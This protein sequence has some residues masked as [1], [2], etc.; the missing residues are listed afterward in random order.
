[1][2]TKRDLINNLLLAVKIGI[3]SS[4]AIYI[5]ELL[6]LEY[7]ASAGTIALLTLMTSKWETVRLSLFR[8]ITFE[9]SVLFSA[10]LF[11]RI[12]SLWISY[13]I[14]VFLIVTVCACLGWKATISVN[15]VVGL[16]LITNQDFSMP[17][18]LNELALVV[19][20]ITMAIVLNLFH[21]NHGHK[22]DLVR[23]MREVEMSLKEILQELNL[24]LRNEKVVDHNDEYTNVWEDI[25]R[26]ERRLQVFIQEAYQYQ[27]NTF[28][29]HPGYF[30]DYF[31]MRMNQTHVLHNL[32]YEIK[33]IK[34][35]PAQAAVIAAFIEHM[36]KFVVE[37]NEP[38]PQLEALEDIFNQMKNEPLPVTREEFE[39]RAMLYHILM[40]LEEFLV[41]KMRF[42]KGLT[43][44][45]IKEYWKNEKL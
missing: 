19:I 36:R 22:K 44:R 28:H 33:K 23:N 20:G 32:H 9:C 13:G 16:H 45:Q 4:V 18:I 14:F 34:E 30:I 27:E 6:H 25:C 8:L 1:M 35:M 26:L 31:E 43:D 7:T 3:G 21:D 5:A 10:I 41:F 15:A 29:S 37:F 24:Y 40:D 39:S 12:D 17:F 2:Q 38:I 11:Q 42:I